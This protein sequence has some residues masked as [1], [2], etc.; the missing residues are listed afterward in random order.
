M[1]S[2]VSVKKKQPNIDPWFESRP[3]EERSDF[4]RRAARA[5]WGPKKISP[6]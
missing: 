4:F 3:Q 5:Q 1:N 6:K 2:N